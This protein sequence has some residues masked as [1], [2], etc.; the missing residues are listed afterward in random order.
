MVRN[1][2]P[3]FNDPDGDDLTYTCTLT[4]VRIATCDPV[5]SSPGSFTIAGLQIGS[6]TVTVTA[7]EVVT[8]G[9]GPS[10]TQTFTVTVS[11]T[12]YAGVGELTLVPSDTS[13]LV[14]WTPPT[15]SGTPTRYELQWAKGEDPF[16]G[17][18]VTT[19][20][21]YNISGLEPSTRY[22]VQVRAAY[23]PR[24]TPVNRWS[25]GDATTTALP[26]NQPPRAAAPLAAVE[27]QLGTSANV[28][29]AAAFTDDD[30]PDSSLTYDAFSG[31]TDVVS[32]SRAGM[33][34]TVTGLKLGVSTVTVTADDGNDG[35]ERPARQTFEVTVVPGP[36][37]QPP[38]VATPIA[39]VEI[40]V[41]RTATA[42]LAV[43]GHGLSGA[44]VEHCDAHGAH[45]DQR[46]QV[47]PGPPLP[48]ARPGVGDR[49]CRRRRE[50]H[51]G[52]FVLVG[53]LPPAG[54]VG[55]EE[56]ADPS[57]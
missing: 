29:I 46:L 40:Q 57:D 27:F 45:V 1:V 22:R 34:L 28:I 44:G 16:G 20:S 56:V 7:T 10:A 25:A 37:N 8:S 51:E 53:E 14:S 38:Q 12:V 33:I 26:V 17:V 13:I 42:G 4:D 39:P 54:L 31:R 48:P 52:I 21:S 23:G 30:D 11:E 19:H 5:T 32:V 18:Q 43:Q 41:G 3:F 47:G 50:E 49:R 24:G 6:T 55:E 36:V 35:P 2:V 9:T 15:D